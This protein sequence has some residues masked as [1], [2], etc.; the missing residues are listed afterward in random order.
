MAAVP[1]SHEAQTLEMAQAKREGLSVYS[2]RP[3]SDE[4][5]AK[6]DRKEGGW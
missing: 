3:R 6:G 4:V 1:G 2:Y 5:V